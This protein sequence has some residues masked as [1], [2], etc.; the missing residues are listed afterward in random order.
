M[1]VE[2][3]NIEGVNNALPNEAETAF[4]ESHQHQNIND[5]ALQLS[6]MPDLRKDLVLRQING[7]QKI[8]TKVPTWLESEIL[9]PAKI[10]MEQCSSQTTAMFKAELI[11]GKQLLDLTGGLGVDTFFLSKRFEQVSY[12]EQN[13]DLAAIAKHNF[14][15][16]GAKNIS[17]HAVNSIDYLQQ[18][19]VQADWIFLDPGRRDTTKRKVFLLEDCTPDVAQHQDLLLSSAANIL[20][21]L[22]PIM[23]ITALINSLKNVH[24]CWVIAV[25]NEVKELLVHFSRV[26]A[27]S[28]KITAINITENERESITQNWQQSNKTI[29]IGNLKKYLYEPNRAVL[30]AGLQDTLGLKFELEKV[31]QNSNFYTSDFLNAAYNG[32]I[33]SITDKLKGK[34]KNLK[35]YFPNK[36][37]NIIARN[38]PLKAS[39]L[40]E[41]YKIIPGGDKYLIATTLGVKDK[42]LLVGERLK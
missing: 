13:V 30:K 33:F 26:A 6:R 24:H 5:V 25:K 17:V 12:F 11:K 10:S 37:A 4:I 18:N 8:G 23:D 32:R 15:V 9:Y 7:K 38:Y 2:E 1:G 28:P 14:K 36:K 29:S 34:T 31:G 22:S 40:F 35:Q 27:D 16:L 39:Q 42:V 21:K 3:S 20:V 19:K 41:K